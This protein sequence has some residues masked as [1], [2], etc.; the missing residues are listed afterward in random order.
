MATSNAVSREAD[1]LSISG[2]GLPALLKTS[3]GPFDLVQGY[4]PRTPGTRKKA[5][6]VIRARISQKRFAAIRL[7]PTYPFRL[8]AW[9][10]IGNREGDAEAEQQDLDTAV[11]L[12]LQRVS[13]LLRD[14]TH[15]GRFLSVAEDPPVIDVE[16][17][18]PTVTIHE[19]YLRADITYSA[20]DS[21]IPG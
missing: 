1:W 10:P 20:D 17:A 13:G 8:I 7:M 11:D 18:D 12:V 14:K 5:L 2:D 6:Y 19:G 3:G 4:F 21:E 9:W 15:G 16:F